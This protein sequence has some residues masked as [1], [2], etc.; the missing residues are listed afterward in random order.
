MSLSD[1]PSKH[2]TNMEVRVL[3]PTYISSNFQPHAHICHLR[4]QMFVRVALTE[5]YMKTMKLSS[6]TSAMFLCINLAMAF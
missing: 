4:I 2:S 5:P 6:V 3:L 1:S